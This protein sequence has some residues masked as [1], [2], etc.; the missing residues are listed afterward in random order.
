[1]R[2]CT[3]AGA[4]TSVMPSIATAVAD[5]CDA[6]LLQIFGGQTRQYRAIDVVVAENGSY[7]SSPSP[8]SHPEMSMLRKCGAPTARVE[9]L[10]DCPRIG[11]SAALDHAARVEDVGRIEGVLDPARQCGERRRLRLEHRDRAAQCL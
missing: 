3:D 2:I 8:R 11:R 1:M 4:V 5:R 6:E 9:T 7:C 10:D